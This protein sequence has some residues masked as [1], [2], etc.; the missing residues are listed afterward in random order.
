MHAFNVYIDESGDEGFTFKENNTG[1]SRWFVLSAAITRS[2]SDLATVKL[3][4]RVR[5]MLRKQPRADLHFRNLHHAQ[6][7]PYMQEIAQARIRTISVLVH[8]P[9]LDA[10]VYSAKGLL[11]NYAT[12]LLLERVSWLC[13]DHRREPEHTAKLVFSNRSNMSY[14]ELRAYLG[15]LKR[16]SAESDIRID[17]SAVDSDNVEIYEHKKRMGL[18]I[19]DAV[20]S[21]MW[22]GVNPNGYGY[23]EPRYAE[24]LRPTV[25]AFNGRRFGYGIKVMPSEVV[26]GTTPHPGTEWLRGEGW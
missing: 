26:R 21:A 3:V 9:S 10:D 22:N 12:R 18:Q 15:K 4:D 6:R 13:R 1:S 23:T 8:K 14:A 20:A 2:E 24:M 5:E 17:W 11:Y 7:L 16:R 25:Y 19:A